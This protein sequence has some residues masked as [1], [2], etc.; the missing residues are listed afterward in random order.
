MGDDIQSG[1][2]EEHRVHLATILVDPL[3]L[4]VLSIAVVQACMISQCSNARSL[5]TLGHGI[6]VIP[7]QAVHYAGATYR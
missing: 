5:E 6:T 7:R 1:G 3:A 4:D 2:K